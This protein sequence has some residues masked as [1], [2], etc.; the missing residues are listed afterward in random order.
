M[1]S[2]RFLLG[3]LIIGILQFFPSEKLDNEKFKDIAKYR[4]SQKYYP[5]FKVADIV[6]L[7]G[8]AVARITS[9]FMVLTNDGSKHN[10]GLGL[11]FEAKALKVI[12][13][14]RKNGRHWEFSEKAV[15]LLREYKEKYP[16]VMASLHG[17]G[18]GA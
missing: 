13:Y 15:D 16:E 10:L 5:S 11:K 4:M 6:G 3:Y 9:N 2:I 1:L 18:D 8:L 17:N 7:S 12:D 14:S